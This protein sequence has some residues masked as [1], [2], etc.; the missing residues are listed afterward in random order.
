M[1]LASRDASQTSNVRVGLRIQRSVIRLQ[2]VILA[3]YV[4]G[5]SEL[6][7]FLVLRSR[8]NVVT[9]VDLTRVAKYCIKSC[10]TLVKSS[11]ITLTC[12]LISD[13]LNKS[14]PSVFQKIA[15]P[16]PAKGFLGYVKLDLV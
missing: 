15:V 7:C 16:L 2:P 3:Y 5:G 1:P 10:A 13:H 11:N 9:R 12:N 14:H 8:S 4:L 6:H